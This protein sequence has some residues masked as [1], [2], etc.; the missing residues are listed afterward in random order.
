MLTRIVGA[1]P[2]VDVTLR[3]AVKA[4]PYRCI[5]E[6]F[7]T[8]WGLYWNPTSKKACSHNGFPLFRE[9][10]STSVCWR[11]SWLPIPRKSWWIRNSVEHPVIFLI[12]TSRGGHGM[13]FEFVPHAKRHPICDRSF[14]M[15]T[16]HTNSH[17]PMRTA[18]TVSA[19]AYIGFYL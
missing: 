10:P 1:H 6:S 16:T 15:D 7:S 18:C 19:A 2:T 12:M 8:S 4:L 17:L 9:W 5:T 13:H 11:C 3:K 14:S